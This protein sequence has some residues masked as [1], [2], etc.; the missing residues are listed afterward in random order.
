MDL[1]FPAAENGGLAVLKEIEESRE[2]VV[3]EDGDGEAVE[4]NKEEGKGKFDDGEE[5]QEGSRRASRRKCCQLAKEKLEKLSDESYEWEDK[6]RNRR[7]WKRGDE[8]TERRGRKPKNDE[9]AVVQEK[10]DEERILKKRGRKPKNVGDEVGV[11]EEKILK[12]RG[13]KPLNVVESEEI[14]DAAVVEEKN[15]Q[16]SLKRKRGRKPL[17]TSRDE[18]P[19]PEDTPKIEKNVSSFGIL[20]LIYSLLFCIF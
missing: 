13:R 8:A 3:K 18:E 6:R 16:R 9:A 5:L 19:K 15:E 7:G 17:N 10:T 12:K 11:H 14:G 2:R 1:N 4:V 20:V